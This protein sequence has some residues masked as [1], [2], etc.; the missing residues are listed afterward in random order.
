MSK[1]GFPRK[2]SRRSLL[3][4]GAAAAALPLLSACQPQVVEKVVTQVVEREKIVEKPVEKIVTQIVEKEKIV[5][6]IVEKE[7]I[8]VVTP[9]AAPAPPTPAATTPIQRIRVAQSNQIPTL[10]AMRPQTVAGYQASVLISGQL[11]RFDFDKTPKPDLVESAEVSADGKTIT[12]KLKPNLKYSDGTPVKA[13]DAVYQV[14]LQRKGPGATF[15]NPVDSVTAP[16]DRTLIWKLKA[17]YPEFYHVLAFQY[18]AMH[19]RSK[20]ESDK[21]YYIRPVSAGPYLL[22][23]WTPGTPRA[24]LV[25]NPN[26]VGGPM[27]VKE[28]ELVA[29]PDLTSRVLQLATGVVDFVFDLPHSSAANLPKEVRAGR[30]PL[31]GM[32]HL[33]YNFEKPTPF[34]KDV[35]VR[36]AMSLAIDREAVNQKAF[37]GLSPAAS[38]FIYSE[39]SEHASVLPNGG[40]RD[41]E[42]AKKLLAETPYAKGFEFQFLTWSARPGWK[43]AALI[44]AE[45]L[46]EIGIIGKVEPI[47]DAVIV[48]RWTAGD[49][50]LVWTG[51]V[52]MPIFV[53]TTLFV[54]GGSYANA[55]RY[56][57]PQL[58]DMI[59]KAQVEISAS[60][61]KE[62]FDEIQKAA[63]AD[64]PHI[65]ISDRAVLKG[66]RIREGVFDVVKQ[67]EYLRVKTVAEM[68]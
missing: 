62:M 28:I 2:L 10:D 59:A 64:M 26:Y 61:R 36:Q 13:D 45:N 14:E 54:P 9:T 24:L 1:I 27:M 5:E 6:K 37:F 15:L 58:V 47:E 31:G 8:V 39:V 3:K 20:V 46:K 11:Y 17:P 7:K 50:E 63:V 48:S 32:Y 30:H 55:A 12:M 43:E 19:P 40:K 66:S 44:I 33:T 68:K 51:T 34:A 65:P 42:A 22:K 18:V 4:L 23:E 53:L 35:K 60:K 38:G 41:V 29:I 49:Y 16:D 21:D 56:K 25:E 57:N 67:A 52:A